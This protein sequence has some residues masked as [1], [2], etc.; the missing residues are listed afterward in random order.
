MTETRTIRIELRDLTQDAS[1]TLVDA[2]DRY[3][4]GSDNSGTANEEIVPTLEPGTHYIR[5]EAEARTGTVSYQL[6]YG[7]GEG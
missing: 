2:T 5:V 1:L 7:V 3:L 6:R 4:T